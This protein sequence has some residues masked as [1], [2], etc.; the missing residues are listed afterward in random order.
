M[1]L[2]AEP[3][4]LFIRGGYLGVDALHQ[5]HQGLDELSYFRR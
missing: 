1:F 5:C 2:R 3:G 4:E